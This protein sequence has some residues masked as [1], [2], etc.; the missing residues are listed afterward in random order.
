MSRAQLAA[1][2]IRVYSVSAT[3]RP[4]SAR[5][6]LQE[7]VEEFH[8][9]PEIQERCLRVTANQEKLTGGA[10]ERGAGYRPERNWCSIQEPLLWR[11]TS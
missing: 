7:H 9:D 1:D 10:W 5:Q 6:T 4:Q 2:T 11:V 8:G 3:V